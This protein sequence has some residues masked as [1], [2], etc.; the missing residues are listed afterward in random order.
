[1]RVL[2]IDVG[3]TSVQSTILDVDTAQAI[4]PVAQVSF[5]VDHP[6]PEAAEVPPERLWSALAAA[7]REVTRGV[8]GLEGLGLSVMTPALVLLDKADRPTAMIWTPLDRRARQAARQAEAA[9]GAEFLAEIGNRPLPGSISA[10]SFRQ[11]LASDPYLIRE[12]QH[13]LHLN[14]WLALRMTGERAF[15]RANAS[16]SGLYGTLT[17]RQWS[18]RW[19]DY[20]EVE[21]S[22]L[23]PVVCGSTIVGTLRSAVAAELGVPGGL[24]LKLGTT[25][26]SIAVLAVGMEPGDLM[27]SVGDSQVLTAITDRPRAAPQRMVCQLGMGEAFLHITQNPVGGAALRWLRD[28]CFR[29]QSEQEFYDATIPGALERTSKVTFDPPFLDGDCL[30]IEARRAAFRDLTLATDRL[31]LLA[32]LLQAMR[33]EHEKAVAALGLGREFRRVYFTGKDAAIVRELI[34]EYAGATEHFVKENPLFG[35]AR[36]FQ[37]R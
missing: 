9:V 31:D 21:T 4:G 17:T 18:P 32:A 23:P 33:K 12:V 36:L 15:D 30:A 26:T 5:R 37:L 14:G 6:R 19:C 3:T 16:F 34:P 13:Y 24:P 29:D 25:T 7:A 22:W 1:M 35:V 11:M 20:F 2:A 10:L 8:E 28:L 27:H